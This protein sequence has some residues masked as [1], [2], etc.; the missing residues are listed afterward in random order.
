MSI[1]LGSKVMNNPINF[2]CS[3]RLI[4]LAWYLYHWFYFNYI[5]YFGKVHISLA[6][7]ESLQ[8]DDEYVGER[9]DLCLF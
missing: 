6:E 8:M 7:D 9:V 1:A 2:I 5:V 3:N 4:S